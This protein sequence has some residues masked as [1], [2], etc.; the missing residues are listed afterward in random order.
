MA[1]SDVTPTEYSTWLARGDRAVLLDVRDD[2]EHQLAHIAGALHIPMDQV[3]ERLAELDRDTTLVVMCH[4]G[5][6]SLSIANFLQQNG[7]SAVLNLKGGINA[8][9]IEVDTRVARY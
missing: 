7:F 5:G 8:W 1:V 2:W 9:A 6:R 3:P 4:T